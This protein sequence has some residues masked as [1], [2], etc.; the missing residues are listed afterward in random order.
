MSLFTQRRVRRETVLD[1]KV[2]TLL[3]RVVTPSLALIAS[4]AVCVCCA[5]CFAVVFIGWPRS[6][7][8]IPYMLCAFAAPALAFVSLRELWRS[9]W[10]IRLFFV[11]LF[12]LAGVAF[13][14]ATTYFVIH[15]RAY[16][17]YQIAAANA[18]WYIQF[19]FAVH[20]FL[21]HQR[22]GIGVISLVKF[23]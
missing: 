8:Q 20:V 19:R 4:F 9:G 2:N 11:A 10:D 17:V 7:A 23:V 21:Y 6:W 16:A 3:S 14:C 12:S 15:P 5:W 22:G 1:R 18:G 13:W